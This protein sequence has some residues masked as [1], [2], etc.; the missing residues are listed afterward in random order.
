MLLQSLTS[1]MNFIPSGKVTHSVHV[2]HFFFGA[3][4]IALKKD[5]S[6]RKL[7]WVAPLNI[8]QPRVQ[9]TTS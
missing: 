7:P 4:L 3:T 6:V 8:W 5:G 9:G 1:F 2:R